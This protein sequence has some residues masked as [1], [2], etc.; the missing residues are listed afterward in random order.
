MSGRGRDRASP[1]VARGGARWAS[2]PRNTV[3]RAGAAGGEGGRSAAGPS[4]AA[5]ACGLVF[6]LPAGL[7]C[8]HEGS[9]I[10]TSGGRVTSVAKEQDC[11]LGHQGEAGAG[12]QQK[13]GSKRVSCRGPCCPP[14]WGLPPREL[15]ACPE[16]VCLS[17]PAQG[18]MLV[19]DITNEKSFDN[20]RNW[21]RNIEEVSLWDPIPCICVSERP[22]LPMR[23]LSTEAPGGNSLET[24]RDGNPHSRPWNPPK[25]GF[26]TEQPREP[27]PQP[28]CLVWATSR[29]RKETQCL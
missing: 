22:G 16:P 1:R 10:W 29:S 3:C 27:V 21:I 28:G 26:V 12:A 15:A 4:L 13:E 19:Y 8:K 5:K 11:S 23:S 17:P 20:I 14:C 18:I 2:G 25:R 24:R 9:A 7:L 6:F